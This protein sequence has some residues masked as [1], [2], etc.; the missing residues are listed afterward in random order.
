MNCIVVDDNK[1]ARL[2]LRQLIE[3][4]GILKFMRE[5]DNPLDAYNY[6]KQEPTDLVF[7]DIE[8]PGMSGIELVKSLEKRPIIVLISAKREYAVEAFELNVADYLVKPVDLPRFLNAVSR[9]KELFDSR[10]GKLEVS[11]KEKDY[12][13]VRSNSVL[14]KIRINDIIYVQALGDYVNIFTSHGRNTVHI[15][16]KGMEEKLSSE[17]FYRVHRSYLIAVDHVDRVEEET[18]YIGKHP[19]P[20]GEQYKKDLLKNLNLI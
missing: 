10:G 18:A 7:L 6:L 5:F 12:V 8:M 14:T 13:F 3:Q 11:E 16:L 2:A 9:A 15:T 20:I 19:I 17:K 4:V 1:L